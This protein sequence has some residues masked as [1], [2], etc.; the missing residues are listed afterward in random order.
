MRF[1][2]LDCYTDEPAGLGVP[3]YIGTYPRYIAGAVVESKNEVFYLT[4]DDLRFYSRYNTIDNENIKK[5]KDRVITNIKIKNLSKNIKD[6]EKI[7]NST[8]VLIIVS[9]VHTPG[10]YLTAVPGTT[11]EVVD[12][13]KSIK[14]KGFTVLTGPGAYGSGLYGGKVSKTIQRDH[15]NFNMVIKDLEYKFKDILENNFTEDVEIDYDYGDLSKI[16]V[17]GA[18]VVKQ[19]PDYPDLIAEIETARGCDRKKGCSFCTEPLKYCGIERRSAS[20]IIKEIKELNSFGV[21]NFRLG[22]QSCFYSYGTSEEIEYLLKNAKKYS[23]VLHIDNVN[24]AKVDEEKTKIVVKYCTPGNI[25]AFGVES[26]DKDVVKANNL[27]SDPETTYEAVKILNK[28][29]AERGEN[30]MPKF[31]PGINILFGLIKE[32]RKTHD[33]NMFWL[34]KILD[35]GLSVRRINIRQVVAF[36]GTQLY[37]EC[38]DRYIK[39]NKKYYWK[40]RDEIRQKVD[41]PMLKRVLPE[42]TVLRDVRAEIYDGKTTFGRQL[43]TYPLIVGIKGRQELNQFYNVKITGHMLRSVIG[44]L[45]K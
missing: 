23:K 38:G 30:G 13:L 5:E 10:K 42:G 19:H 21:N 26:F 9:G 43:G 25:A 16:S 31:L 4:I 29:G 14:F 34:K 22:K 24:P 1:T 28:Y 40:W 20:D 45:D 37:N 12:I 33:E 35:D 7:L 36:P 11:K 17:L 27:N 3:P 32:S 6:I 39:K 15:D 41:Y 18:R 44:E 2:I 8:D